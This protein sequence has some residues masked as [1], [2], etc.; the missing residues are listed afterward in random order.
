MNKIEQLGK[1]VQLS[2]GSLTRID[3][4]TDHYYFHD[5]I[6]HV[7][8]THMLDIGAPFPEG[9]R[10][11]L[12]NTDGK[13]SLEYMNM[14][15]DRGSKLHDALDRM[16]RKLALDK[17][18]Y[19]TRYEREALMSF[20][21]FM[22]FLQ[23]QKFVTEFVVSDVEKRVSGTVDFKGYVDEQ[24]LEMVLDPRKYLDR[25]ENGDFVVKESFKH[26]L[27]IELKLVKIIID[28]KFTARNAYNHKVQVAKYAQMDGLSYKSELPVDRKFTWRYSALHKCRFDFQ[29][30]LLDESSFDRIYDTALE[31]LG[32]FPEPPEVV[33]YPDKFILFE[34]VEVKDA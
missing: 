23:P 19:P 26:L 32:G 3:I 30:S 11:W 34:D 13:E 10:Q 5:G 6:F 2:N 14:T 25:D 22:K 28:W 33:V 24:R 20:I 31:Y 29:E 27:E 21:R 16:M 4:D 18:D 1:T 15:K 8:L 7:S 12:R 17:E 9:I